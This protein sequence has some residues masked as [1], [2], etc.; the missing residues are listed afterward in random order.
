MSINTHCLFAF[1]AL[2]ALAANACSS[3]PAHTARAGS[4]PIQCAG[5]VIQSEADS[6]RFAGCSAVVGDLQVAN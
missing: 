2:L 6:A 5:G 3:N 4:A 1:S